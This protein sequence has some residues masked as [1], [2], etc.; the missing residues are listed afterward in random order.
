VEETEE[1]YRKE[2]RKGEREKE[3]ERDRGDRGVRCSCTHRLGGR[4]SFFT[5]IYVDPG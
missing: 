5:F 1:R 3:R 2:D 4:N